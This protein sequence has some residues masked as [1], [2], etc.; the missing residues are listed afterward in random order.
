MI[1]RP[2]ITS[3]CTWIKRIPLGAQRRRPR[4]LALVPTREK[5]PEDTAH[6]AGGHRLARR[7]KAWIDRSDATYTTMKETRNAG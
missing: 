7:V 4:S 6:A 3:G 1:S 2:G 5:Q